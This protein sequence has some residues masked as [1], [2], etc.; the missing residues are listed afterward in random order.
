M[1]AQAVACK[2][3]E[4]LN[5][6]KG[7]ENATRRLEKMEARLLNLIENRAEAK[8]KKVVNVESLLYRTKLNFGKRF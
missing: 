5:D 3:L 2:I 8:G 1:L 7:L 6:R 4:A